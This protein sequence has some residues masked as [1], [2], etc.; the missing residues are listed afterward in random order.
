MKKFYNIFLKLIHNLFLRI[1]YNYYK[2][3][4]PKAQWKSL[5]EK[6]VISLIIWKSFF[7]YAMINAR[8]KHC[9]VAT[10]EMLHIRQV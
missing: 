7:V 3:F 1:H 5:C 6:V 9:A 4:L 8:S 10:V 2:V